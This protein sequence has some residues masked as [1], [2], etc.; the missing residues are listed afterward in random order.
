MLPSRPSR[1]LL[2]AATLVAALVMPLGQAA[3]AAP[4]DPAPSAQPWQPKAAPKPPLRPADNRFDH[5]QRLQREPKVSAPPAP[6]PRSVTTGGRT[7]GPLSGPATA[8]HGKKPAVAPCTLDGITGLS[9]DQ[10]ADFLADPAVTADGCLRGLIWNWD[11]RLIP[12]MSD[13][14]VQAVA[15]RIASLAPG[16]DGANTSHLYEMFTYLHA[17]AYHD[18]SHEEIDTTDAPTVNAVRGAVDAFAAAAHTFAPPGPTPIPC[19]RP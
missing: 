5:A 6:A 16:H 7:P 8:H 13:A 15:R 17:M 3:A 11:S 19:A 14:H 9:P 10:L 18:F 4:R 1:R 2:L 12:V